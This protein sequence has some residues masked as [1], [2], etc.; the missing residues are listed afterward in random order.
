MQRGYNLEQIKRTSFS[1]LPPSP[2]T[3]EQLRQPAQTSVDSNYAAE[4][5]TGAA[6]SSYRNRQ[7]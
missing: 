5:W 1:G 4:A 3:L 7:R 6:P 2:H